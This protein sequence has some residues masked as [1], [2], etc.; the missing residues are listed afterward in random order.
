VREYE[1][2][3]FALLNAYTSGAL[4]GIDELVDELQQFRTVQAPLLIHSGGGSI[5]VAEGRRAPAVLAESGPA[6][7]VVGPWRFA[8]RKR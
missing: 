8:G 4:S 7:G 2:T 6:A 3:T 1:R 5:S